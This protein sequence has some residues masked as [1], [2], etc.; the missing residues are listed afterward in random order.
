MQTREPFE[1]LFG[2]HK[3]VIGMVHLKPLPGAPAY[4]GSM[5]A[6][7]EAALADARALEQGGVNGILVENFGDAPFFKDRVPPETIAAMARIVTVLRQ[8]TT[9][10]LGVNVLRND[11]LAALAIAT[12]CDAQFVRVNVASWAML[13][14][15]GLIEGRAA[16]LAR[17]RKALD[18][19]VLI[20]ADCLTKHA[21]PLA[22]MEMEWVA[23]DTWERGGVN[24]LVISGKAT[25]FET[26]LAQVIAARQGAPTAPI[27]IG[28]G[29]TAENL[30]AFLPL[31]DGVL[32]GTWLKVGGQVQNPVDV[33]RVR[34][35]VERTRNFRG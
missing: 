12:A 13:A 6:I 23:R 26:E 7:V 20:F 21:V 10:P 1:R 25:G 34:T 9:L 33:T 22:T 17:Y 5:N 3:V 31:A 24:A 27:L 8:N 16:E 29:I 35:L 15:Q 28:S 18:S 11:A 14:D 30:S 32:V 4:Q 19:N 2:R